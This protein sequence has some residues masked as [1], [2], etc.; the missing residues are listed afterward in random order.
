MRYHKTFN[1]QH[2]KQ[3]PSLSIFSVFCFLLFV[4]CFKPL[5]AQTGTMAD[6]SIAAWERDESLL[7][8]KVDRYRSGTGSM[9]IDLMAFPGTDQAA[10]TWIKNFIQTALAPSRQQGHA[11]T[12]IDEDSLGVE[13]GRLATSSA[14]IDIATYTVM[15]LNV[16]PDQENRFLTF[17]SI[18]R[19]NNAVQLSL[20]QSTNVEATEEEV[21]EADRIRFNAR[22]PVNH[23][24][25]VLGLEDMIALMTEPL[26]YP[27]NAT[28]GFVDTKPS[29][30]QDQPQVP[31]VSTDLSPTQGSFVHSKEIAQVLF[32]GSPQKFD[33]LLLLMDGTARFNPATPIDHLIATADK[34]SYPKNWRQWRMHEGKLQV[35]WLSSM[36]DWVTLADQ[37]PIELA[38]AEKGQKLTGE[39]THASTVSSGTFGSSSHFA[40]FVFSQDGRYEVSE[41]AVMG[42]LVPGVSTSGAIGECSSDRRSAAANSTASG[43][44]A[45]SVEQGEGCGDA[46]SGR[47]Y[48]DGFTIEFRADNGKVFRQP[49]Y[50][51]DQNTV[52][53]GGRWFASAQ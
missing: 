11:I 47:Y 30:P 26:L 3:I 25:S 28:S 17:R 9:V 16:D 24:A 48:L 12:L 2:L 39:W 29:S 37:S 20:L 13:K 31:H 19:E 44:S 45:G 36:G 43:G 22:I 8:F 52:I 18:I 14:G 34:K 46:N 40:H 10:K 49:F 38:R 33:I 50:R 27:Q 41:T 23:S 42:V 6:L 32:L 4:S 15:I 53:I 51:L 7:G 1:S 35:R 5:F 21:Q